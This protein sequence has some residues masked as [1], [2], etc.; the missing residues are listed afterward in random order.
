MSDALHLLQDTI[1]AVKDVKAKDALRADAYAHLQEVKAD[2]Q[3]T[4]DA[5]VGEAQAAY[6]AAAQAH[7]AAVEAGEALR[8]QMQD[9][10][11]LSFQVADPRFRQSR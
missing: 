1:D 5:V 2:A 8:S 3:K 7:K 11:G 9:A 4:F 6:D 10:L